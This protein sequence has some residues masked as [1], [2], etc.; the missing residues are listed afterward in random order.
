MK[1]L[2]IAILLKYKFQYTKIN[3]HVYILY[4]RADNVIEKMDPGVKKIKVKSINNDNWQLT[5]TS[6]IDWKFATCIC[7]CM[8]I[9][10]NPNQS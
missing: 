1:I 5:C 3:I 9:V 7:V 10:S 4:V 2:I 8:C 6:T